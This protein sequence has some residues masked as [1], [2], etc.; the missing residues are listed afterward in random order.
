MNMLKAI[1]LPTW[2]I[3]TSAVAVF[4]FFMWASWAEID[5][6]TRGTGKVIPV[7]KVQ[8]IQSADGGVID[9]IRVREGDVVNKGQLLVLIDRIKVQSAVDESRAKVAAFRSVMSRIEA[10]L[11]DRPLTFP[12]EVQAFPDFVTN[13]TALYRKRRQAIQAEIAS[14]GSVQGLMQQELE[15][16]LPLVASGDVARAEIIRMQRGIADIQGQIVNKRSKYQQDLQAEFA[17][18][19][20]EMV[21]AK[22]VLAQRMDALSATELRSSANGIVKNVR[23][24]TVGA[25]LRPGDEVMQIVPTGERLIVEAQVSPR[26]IAFIKLGQTASIKFDTYDSAIYGSGSGLVSY[27][28]PDT[29]VEQR[30][31]GENATYYR[32]NFD[33]DIADMKPKKPN[34]QIEIQ[35]GMTITAEI[36][37]GENTVLRYL[38]KPI[39]KTV[40]ESFGEK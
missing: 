16:N 4:A 13:Q 10:E 37:T 1:R 19:E 8:I 32:V 11:Y 30:P 5:Q 29:L 6:I 31:D 40:S 33:V 38:T 34:E 20:E 35:P 17:K 22:Q 26:D 27:I 18:V 23:F 28:S 25:V 36:K 15:L 24:T 21:S 39:L 9:E 7:A 14:L 12:A 3:L 2:I